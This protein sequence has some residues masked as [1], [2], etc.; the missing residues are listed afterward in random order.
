MPSHSCVWQGLLRAARQPA[1]A[2]HHNTGGQAHVCDVEQLQVDLLW[3]DRPQCSTEHDGVQ[4]A[5]AYEAP[6]Q[7]C[8][9]VLTPEKLETPSPRRWFDKVHNARCRGLTAQHFL[10]LVLLQL[11]QA[12]GQQAWSR[13]ASK[14]AL[15]NLER[16][17]LLPW[18]SARR[19]SVSH[20]PS[21]MV[22]VPPHMR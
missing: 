9:A 7:D 19:S 6:D 8:W 16:H 18:R 12:G 3:A 5:C 2:A 22:P 1:A 11:L 20:S 21:Q 14:S 10:H 15:H 17:T 4:Q 13:V